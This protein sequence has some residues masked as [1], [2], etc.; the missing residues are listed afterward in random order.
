VALLLSEHRK[1]TMVDDRPTLS[2][3]QLR[4]DLTDRLCAQNYGADP[5]YQDRLLTRSP[6]RVRPKN[7]AHSHPSSRRVS[8]PCTNQPRE[9]VDQAMP[10]RHRQRTIQ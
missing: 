6:R 2:A 5:R 9:G 10:D 3:E 8:L 7:M 1:I 4:T